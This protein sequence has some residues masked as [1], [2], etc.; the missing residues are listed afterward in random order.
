MIR[1]EHLKKEFDNAYPIK[2]VSFT[3]NKGDVI[4]VIGPSGV[5]KSTLLRCL[6]LL[7]TPDSGKIFLDGKE[8]TGRNA[9][10]MEDRLK[11]GMVFQ[12]FNLFSHLTVIENVM[13]APIMV[14]KE[15]RDEAREKAT[16]LL[17]TVGLY[18]K[19][20]N[21]PDELSGG[22]KQRAAIARTLAMDPEVILLDEPTSAL[23]PTMAGEVEVVIDDMAKSGITMIIVTHEMEFAK[24]V[25]NRIIYLDEGIVYEEGT[26]EEIFDN[27]QRG[28]TRAFVQKSKIFECNIES[29]DFDIIEAGNNV[30]QFALWHQLD[31][32]LYDNI[33]DVFQDLLE[34]VLF[35][36]ITDP[37]KINVVMNDNENH[38]VN[39]RFRFNGPVTGEEA[40]KAM[41]GWDEIEKKTS[42]MEYQEID[43]PDYKNSILITM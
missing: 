15:N 40:L 1:V 38:G 14:K 8:I 16:R 12:S 39:I 5:G 3:V 43:E 2:D 4:S 24:S 41:S 30:E 22:Q 42:R 35:P 36:V 27:P 21:Y 6:N 31:R 19:M 17:R 29:K 9:Y 7:E 33:W 10:S 18:D 11:V 26:P 25:S 28:K 13:H 34:Q 20:L 37:I 23:D 32:E